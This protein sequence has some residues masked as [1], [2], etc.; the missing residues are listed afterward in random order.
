MLHSIVGFF[1][2]SLWEDPPIE[3]AHNIHH[4]VIVAICLECLSFSKHIFI[5]IYE[6]DFFISII[7]IT[8][9]FSLPRIHMFPIKYR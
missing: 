7:I 9:K 3:Y 1:D 5:I 8:L 6:I 2:R 4:D